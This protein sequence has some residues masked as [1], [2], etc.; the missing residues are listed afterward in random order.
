MSRHAAVVTHDVSTALTG[1]LPCYSL[2]GPFQP[3]PDQGPMTRRASLSTAALAVPIQGASSYTHIG[4]PSWATLVSIVLHN[5]LM[6]RVR[7]LLPAR[8]DEHLTRG[9]GHLLEAVPPLSLAL[10]PAQTPTEHRRPRPAVPPAAAAAAGV[11]VGARSAAGNQPGAGPRSSACHGNGGNGGGLLT[12]RLAGRSVWP[13]RRRHALWQPPAAAGVGP[14]ST[15][16][17]SACRDTVST[18]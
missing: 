10:L 16:Q 14:Q 11:D 15:R 4:T 18:T 17:C 5:S 7:S 8:P 6:F 12:P 1:W 2:Q 9:A 3:P 13:A